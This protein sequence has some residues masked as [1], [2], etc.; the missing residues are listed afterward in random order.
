ME[1]TEAEI[2]LTRSLRHQETLNDKMSVHH[3]LEAMTYLPLAI[4]QAAAYINVKRIPIRD[5]VSL[6]NSTDQDTISLLAREFQDNT[7]YV[8][9]NNA[10]ATTWLVSFN[11]IR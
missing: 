8:G 5:Y 10:V 11:Q 1:P 4:A 3:L 9:S 7:R 2:F 6:L